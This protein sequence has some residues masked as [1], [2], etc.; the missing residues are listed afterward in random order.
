MKRID[1][2]ADVAEGVSFEAELLPFLSSVNLCCGIHAGSIAESFRW[3]ELLAREYPQLQVG[4]HPGLDDRT[5]QGRLW[6]AQKAPS[7]I[8]AEVQYQVAGMFRL[9]QRAA[10]PLRHLKLHGALYH[11]VQERADW[12]HA[13]IQ[14]ARD[15]GLSLLAQPGTILESLCRQA[16][17]PFI[18]E[19]FADRGY[20]PS[21]R[22]IPRGEPGAL[23]ATVHEAVSQILSQLQHDQFDSLCVHGD[24]P[25]SKDIVQ[26]LANELPRHGYEIGSY[27]KTVLEAPSREE[28]P[29]DD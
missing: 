14:L 16:N 7:E 6:Q 12:S 17:Y 10:V 19:G 3:F 29:A 9:A 15:Y 24:N 8:W 28:P 23:L 26:A 1:L 20:L 27:G 25:I 4:L 21:G 22:L 5:N 2:N 18:R 11:H 13:L